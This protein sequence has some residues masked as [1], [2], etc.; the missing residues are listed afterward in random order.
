MAASRSAQLV[1][2]YL[3]RPGAAAWRQKRL[4][5]L[6]P[7]EKQR[8]A[9]RRW[10]AAPF[11]FLVA[12]VFAAAFAYMY[13][14]AKIGVAGLEINDLETQIQEKQT[15][16]LRTELEIGVL[17]S[18]A[19]VESYAKLHLGMVYPD[20]GAVQYL[21]QQVSNMLAA[22]LAALAAE[23]PEP[24]PEPEAKRRPLLTAWAELISSYFFGAA[25]AISDE[26]LI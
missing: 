24:A 12:L 16:T 22:E 3:E 13:L 14:D 5:L 19:R 7:E 21:D 4:E 23:A 17:S 11:V 25:L 8:L 20:I 15:L 26:Q 6:Q 18:L 2:P 9:K 10:E 1:Q